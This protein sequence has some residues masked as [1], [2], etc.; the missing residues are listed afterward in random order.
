MLRSCVS[1]Q[2]QGEREEGARHPDRQAGQFRRS[3]RSARLPFLLF[4]SELILVAGLAI[5]LGIGA[6]A[7]V[8]KKNFKPRTQG[9]ESIPAL[10]S[11]QPEAAFTSVG[12]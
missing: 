4:V 10:L 1:A 3:V 8:A 12:F 6:I 5:G 11:R 2:R 9:G 7:E